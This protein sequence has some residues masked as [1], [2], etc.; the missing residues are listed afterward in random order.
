MA[1]VLMGDAEKRFI[2]DGIKEDLRV[3]GRQRKDVRPMI[4]ET[5]VITHA[6]GSAR[7]RLA[8]TDVLVGV[9]AELCEDR[10]GGLEFYVDC[11]ANAS[12]EFEGR[13]GEDLA[14][15]ISSTLASSYS[16]PRVFDPS[17]LHVFKNRYAWVLHV[18]VLILE[19]EGGNLFDVSSLAVKSALFCTQVPRVHIVDVDGG[20]PEIEL[21]EDPE[22]CFRLN[23]SGAPVLVSLNRV[24]HFVIVDASPHEE[25][26]SSAAIVVAVTPSGRISSLRK[27]GSGSFHIDTLEDALATAGHVG[28]S[29][30]KALFQKLQQEESLGS[31]RVCSGFLKD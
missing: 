26:C 12:P 31:S 16:D 15:E 24:G 21:S 8:N 5:D 19:V 27:V 9:K 2:L 30:N 28:T 25:A 22:E 11:S 13:G 3:D 29:L 14:L 23:V 6:N 20:V 10:P 4:L 1:S 18:D 17:V 7:I